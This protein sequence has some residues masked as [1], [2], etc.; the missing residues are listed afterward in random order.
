MPTI[1]L[2]TLCFGIVITQNENIPKLRDLV[3]PYEQYQLRDILSSIFEL[4]SIEQHFDSIP[5]TPPKYALR[6]KVKSIS[7]LNRYKQDL[8]FQGDIHLSRAHLKSIVSEH[9]KRQ[10]PRSKRTAFKNAE[11]PKTIWKPHV[12]YVFHNS[13]SA[14]AK[15]SLQAAINFWQQNTCVTFKPRTN[16]G[17]Y[18][19]LSGNDDGCWS[20][21]GRDSN[22]KGQI[23]NIGKGCELFGIT[24]H[25]VA[26]ALGLFHEQSR[27]DRDL[28][29]KINTKKIAQRNY[30]DFAKVGPSNMETYGMTYDIGSVMHYKPNEFS[31]DGS[32][33]IIANDRNLQTTM[34]Q[35]RGPSFLDVAKINR[36]YE[37]SKNCKNRLNCT[38]GGY[39]NPR[40]CNM[41][42]CPTGYGGNT[43]EDIEESNP[44]KCRGIL[45]AEETQRKFTIN[46]KPKANV[47]ELRKCNYHIQ[48][49]EG[50]RV[51]V[52][53]DSVIGNC[54]H[55]CYEESLEL[56][57]YEDK[58][59]TGARFCCKIEKPIMLMSQTNVVPIIM[60]AGKAQAFAQIRYSYVDPKAYRKPIGNSG[61]S[62]MEHFAQIDERFLN[63]PVDSEKITKN[64]TIK[65]D[66][67]DDEFEKMLQKQYYN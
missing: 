16:E 7:H 30:Y 56:K 35:F 39:Q 28:Y 36:H 21:V 31:I 50:K 26:H 58:T 42:I 3:N 24:S 67:S 46:M 44:K 66:I 1:L 49:P 55:G 29:V 8:L 11:Y 51:L 61:A 38:N 2:V 14:S 48:A 6:D 43:C 10:K 5:Y 63:I 52:I 32:A 57:T 65:N 53:V 45:K 41:C 60:I 54:V 64:H 47:K 40:H 13:L 9:L 15:N 33:T 25:E 20:T 4:D 19:L 22:Q 23:L 59:V 62:L 12:P 34:G 27:Y 17:V 18:L 37:C